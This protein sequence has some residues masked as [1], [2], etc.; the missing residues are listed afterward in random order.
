M[1]SFFLHRIAFRRVN[2]HVGFTNCYQGEI[3]KIRNAF[4]L[5][6]GL[7]V[8]SEVPLQAQ[9]SENKTGKAK[10]GEVEPNSRRN[11]AVMHNKMSELHKRM[12]ACFESDRPFSE[13]QQMMA[14]ACE[15]MGGMGRMMGGRGMMMMECPI[16]KETKE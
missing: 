10:S 13:C 2:G 4:F 15:E 5:I 9:S 16:Q 8:L 3:M 1:W 14:G 6:V 11:L 12:A 7:A